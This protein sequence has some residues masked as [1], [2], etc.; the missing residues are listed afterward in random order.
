MTEKV[1]RSLPSDPTT[2]SL[3]R[4]QMSRRGFLAATGGVAGVALLASCGSDTEE[5]ASTTFP[6]DVGGTVRWANW[7]A[8]LDQKKVDG[9]RTYPSL[10]KFTAA[11]GIA[12]DYLVDYNDND[13]FYGKVQENLKAGN[14]IG[15]DIVTPTDWMAA[16]WIRL[17][18]AREL[19]AANVPNK[20]NILDTLA[21]VSF[22]PGRNYSL[23]WQSGFAGFCWNK[24]VI[25]Q[26]VTTIEQ[27]FSPANKGRVVVLSE[28]RDTMGIILQYQGVD[29]SQ[30]FT[31]DQFMNAIDYFKKMI[32]DGFIRQVK[33]N[34]YL[35][36][37]AN[38][39]AVAAI[40]WS[41]D[42]FSENLSGQNYGF[43]IPESG[44]T[45]W[46]DNMLIAST[47]ANKANSEALMNHYYDPAIAAEVAAWVNY[48][49]P[50]KGAQGEMEK[51]DPELA[52]SPFIFPDDTTLAKV[53]VFRGLEAEEEFNFSAAFQEA[54]G[55]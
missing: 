25:K 18:Y 38:G 9:K 43:A 36:D 29:I 49:C 4:A 54:I 13:E 32:A 16:R 34:D 46:S 3:I 17:G 19:D 22:D 47:S 55:A 37:M 44:G 50:V 12:V 27:L 10:D 26:D 1:N 23:T 51:I 11:T 33:G 5:G 7:T 39:D 45:L 2:R 42:M 41:G 21:N 31:E 48:I 8:Y 14:D 28:M 52:S 53:K 6:E 35:E 40:G 30:P 20:G 24:N 15:Y